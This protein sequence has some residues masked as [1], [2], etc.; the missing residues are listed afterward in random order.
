MAQPHP[1]EAVPVRPYARRWLERDLPALIERGVVPEDVATRIRACYAEGSGRTARSWGTAVLAVLGAALIGGGLILLLAHNWDAL[2]RPM[3][4]AIALTPLAVSVVTGVVAL[5]AGRGAA[6][7]EGIGAFQ[8]LATVLA[9]ALVGQTYHFGGAFDDLMR[10]WALLTLPLI[11]ALDATLPALFYLA[12]LLVWAGLLPGE[13]SQRLAAIGG[14]LLLAPHLVWA[15]RRQ[16]SH[17]RTLLLM[18]AAALALPIACLIALWPYDAAV[19]EWQIWTTS[20]F[21]AMHLLGARRAPPV[22]D[23][24]TAPWRWV[25]GLGV[26]SVALVSS[27]REAWATPFKV[28]TPQDWPG[29]L[30]L[31]AAVGLALALG[32]EAT[33]QRAWS[34]T[35]IAALVPVAIAARGAQQVFHGQLSAMLLTL[36]LAA[37]G[38]VR[39]AQGLRERRLGA[40]NAGL[41]VLSAV[42]LARFFDT[43]VSYLWRG[44]AFLAAGTAILAVNL[45]WNRRTRRRER[46]S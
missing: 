33:L 37:F 19:G 41:A 36:A 32:L 1:S 45:L 29:L 15:V 28:W 34:G 44:A 43:D 14:L 16:P 4:A 42:I 35:A 24:W 13:S 8:S 10:T 31:A 46:A 27:F 26:I 9:L 6:W 11:Y 38:L 39:L 2:S 23:A 7:R 17:P 25:G 12:A 5:H 21:A 3:R 30:L 20:L 22:R 18:W 40:V